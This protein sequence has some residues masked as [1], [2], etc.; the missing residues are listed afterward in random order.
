MG[1]CY[2]NKNFSIQKCPTTNQT[3][4]EG[5]IKNDQKNVVTLK[6]KKLLI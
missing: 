1:L 6:E 4:Y 3:T 5:N 2:S